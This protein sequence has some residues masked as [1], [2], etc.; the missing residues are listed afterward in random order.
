MWST[1]S[2]LNKHFDFKQNTAIVSQDLKEQRMQT[3]Q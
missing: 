1:N 2:Y 3:L